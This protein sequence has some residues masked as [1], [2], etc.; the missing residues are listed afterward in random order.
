MN[1]ICGTCQ[2]EFPKTKDY[3]FVR[4]IKQYNAQGKLKIYNSFRSDCKACYSKKSY[5]NKV[6]N[7]CKKLNCNTSEYAKEWKRQYT[8]KRT[9]DLE[10]KEVLTEGQYNHYIKL[11]KKEAVE[12]YD[13]YL[14]RVEKSKANRNEILRNEVLSKQKYFTKEDKRLALRMYSRDESSRLTDS[15]I[16][17]RL[18]RK[19]IKELTPDIIETKRL[20]L[21]LKRELKNNNVKIK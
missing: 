6:K 8:E 1:K 13:D 12:N 14:K 20:T 15:Y 19:K 21:K 7:K 10:A 18:M 4:K 3:F 5:K 17:N 9:I 11:L 2:S 16:A